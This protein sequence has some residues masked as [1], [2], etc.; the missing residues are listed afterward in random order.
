MEIIQIWK[1]PANTIPGFIILLK[2]VLGIENDICQ[3]ATMGYDNS[4]LETLM[5]YKYLNW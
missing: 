5:I 2:Y 3:T 1:T 4:D